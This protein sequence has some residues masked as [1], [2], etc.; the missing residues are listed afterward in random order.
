M[1]IR[2]IR[3][4]QVRGEYDVSLGVGKERQVGALD[5]LAEY[6]ARQVEP[7]T[8]EQLQEPQPIEGIYVHVDTTEGITG[9]FGPI[10][11]AQAYL[12]ATALKPYLLD[13]DPLAVEYLWDVMARHDRHGR[14]GYMMMAISAVDL[15]LWDIRGKAVGWPVYRLLGGPTR[16]RIP[17]YA[18]MLGHSLAPSKVSERARAY[19]KKGYRAQKWF[20]RYGPGH[21]R[22]AIAENMSLVRTL[23]EAVGEDVDLMFDAWL[24]WDVPF[25]IEMGRRMT[26]FHPRWL[27]EP[28]QPDRIASYA[29]IRRE[30]DIPIA[31]GEHVYTR[32]G[33]KT[34]LDAEALDVLQA[35]PDWTGGITEMIKICAL[36]SAYDKQVIPHGHSVV[37][38][39]HVIAAQSPAV[40][41]LLE[42]LVLHNQKK[43]WFHRIKYVPEDGH[44]PLPEQPGLGIELDEER[45]LSRQELTW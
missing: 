38:A 1:R 2:D 45:V 33:F 39:L 41:P 37:P 12:I 22:E 31:G 24:G 6:R 30:T 40:C 8:P 5:M 42:Y 13:K 20:F 10:M 21:G 34:M 36:A 14:T 32:W 25:A 9:L 16:E 29:Q 4:I 26:P 28:V 44:I 11:D 27:E 15:A 18:S 19:V 23:R 7:P 35:D 17:A 43:Q 3:L